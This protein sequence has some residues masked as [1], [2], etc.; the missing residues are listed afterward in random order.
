[1]GPFGLFSEMKPGMQQTRVRV[2]TR[3]DCTDGVVAYTYAF[4]ASH[5]VIAVSGNKVTMRASGGRWIRLAHA[6]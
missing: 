4:N 5:L 3:R 1:M 6:T 2:V